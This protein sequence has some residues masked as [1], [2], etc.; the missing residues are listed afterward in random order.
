MTPLSKVFMLSSEA[1]VD[2]GLL[3]MVLQAGHSR[4]PVYE[5][6]SKQ[7]PGAEGACSAA[8]GRSPGW[9]RGAAACGRCQHVSTPAL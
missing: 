2:K 8:A 3:A 9:H 5:G 4:V 1:L 7:V 6:D